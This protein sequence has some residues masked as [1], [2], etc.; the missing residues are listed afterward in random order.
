M[1]ID[2]HVH[3]VRG[4][5]C[6]VLSPSDL[7]K[8]ASGLGLDGVCITEHNTMWDIGEMKELAC[9]HGFRLF[10]GIEVNTDMGHVLAFGLPGYISG[11]SKAETLRR[12]VDEHGGA[13]VLA[14]PFR[15][16]I[17]S[18]YSFSYYRTN[19]SLTLEE[20][21]DRPIFQLVDAME[22]A[23][24]GATKDEFDFTLEACRRMGIRGT[25]GSDAHSAYGVGC[26]FTM[27][28]GDICSEEDLIR[29]LKAGRVRAVDRR[30][31]MSKL[32]EE[33]ER[34]STI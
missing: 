11:I 23:N 9:E 15:S 3:T 24:G 29:E 30:K 26:C 2:L 13:M 1:I 18:Y 22:V 12:V 28:E 32:L 33:V 34:N 31:Q 8:Y 19:P 25:G 6:S 27:F 14:H 16:D 20:A 10:Q 21:C 17:S 4:S 7:V 5:H